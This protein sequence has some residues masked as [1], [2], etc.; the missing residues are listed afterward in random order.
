[1]PSP[2]ECRAA[3]LLQQVLDG[4]VT[5]RDA[6]GAP[7]GTHDFDLVLPDGR[8]IAVEVTS[9]TDP[10]AEA[11]WRAVTKA[12]WRAPTLKRSWLLDV[13]TGTNVRAMRRRVEPLLRQLENAG[14]WQFDEQDQ[15]VAQ[16]VS[17]GV[18][19][20]AAVNWGQP[21]EILVTGGVGGAVDPEFARMAVEVVARAQDNRNKLLRAGAHERHLVVWIDPLGLQAFASMRAWRST[22]PRYCCLP[23]EVDVLWVGRPCQTDESWR[24]VAEDLWRFTRGTGWEPIRGCGR[25]S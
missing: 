12:S 20:G 6:P 8:T 21:P 16:L 22:P 13:Q 2:Y 9:A 11:F 7:P 1:M 25:H 19:G 5:W 18:R 4:Q 23:P 10:A 3:Q 15:K 14:V 17:L 24:I